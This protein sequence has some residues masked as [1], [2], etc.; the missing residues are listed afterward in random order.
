MRVNPTEAAK[1]ARLL[2]GLLT[3]WPTPETVGFGERLAAVL[4]ERAGNG[5]W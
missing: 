4:E 3:A 1:L 5:E 2:R